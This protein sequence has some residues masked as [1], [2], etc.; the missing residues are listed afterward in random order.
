MDYAPVEFKSQGVEIWLPRFAIAYTDYA[1]R[2]MITEHTFSD[3]E[4][5]SVQ[6]QQVIKLK[7]P[8]GNDV[9]KGEPPGR[10]E[11]TC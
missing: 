6:T 10:I 11:L 8:T 7:A 2:R 9:D 1:R 5:F 3:F 4:L